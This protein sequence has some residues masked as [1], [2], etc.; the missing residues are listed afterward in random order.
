MNSRRQSTRTSPVTALP[1]DGIFTS[2]HSKLDAGASNVIPY[3]SSCH[4]LESATVPNARLQQMQ[5]P[6]PAGGQHGYGRS[7]ARSPDHPALPLPQ[8]LS[9]VLT[10]QSEEVP[11]SRLY[12]A[13]IL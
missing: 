2:C 11:Y 13:L 9:P 12:L 1:E 3:P 5:Q 7:N 6:V 8:P 10:M 4:D